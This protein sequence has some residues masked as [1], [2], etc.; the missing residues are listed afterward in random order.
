MGAAKSVSERFWAKRLAIRFGQP[1]IP[2]SIPFIGI[3]DRLAAVL[4]RLKI[5]YSDTP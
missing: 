1:P 3:G 4:N 5:A 2:L